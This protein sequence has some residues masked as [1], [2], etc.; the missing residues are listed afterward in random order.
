[1]FV[2]KLDSIE[3]RLNKKV[4]FNWL[5]KYGTAF[6]AIDQTGSG[7]VIIGMEK[8]N[9]KY[10]CKIAG[11]DTLEG[12]ISPEQS[13]KELEAAMQ[14]YEDLRVYPLINLV[15]Y[16][17][18]DEYSVAVFDWAEGDCLFD[19]WNFDKYE[20]DSSLIS[21]KKRFF[22]LPI[23]KKIKASDMLFSFLEHT[24]K[25]SYIAVDFYDGSIIYDFDN[26]SLTICDIDFFKKAP[27]I[28]D[29]GV[30]WW[31]TKRLK[32]P[33]EYILNA[34]I[35]ERTNIFTL[36]ALLFDFFGKFTQD[37]INKRSADN[38]FTPCSISNWTLGEA[39]YNVL[40]K[41]T[42]PEREK[43][44]SDIKEF[45]SDWKSSILI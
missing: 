22:N 26:D 6:T 1:M 33:E 11:A 15:E 10:F 13:V 37:D 21:P 14:I 2:N 29:V 32:A 36:G 5:K 40:V 41:A 18:Q 17:T 44:Y 12:E 4:D 27:V 35:D 42:C 31:G 43:R 9:R 7:C 16:F 45:Y 20:K 34:V 3:F 24:H 28:N 30:N 19:H 23:N 25:N 8:N 38:C 39:S